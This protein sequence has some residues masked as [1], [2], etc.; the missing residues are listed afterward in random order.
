MIQAP[1]GGYYSIYTL[2]GMLLASGSI[3]SLTGTIPCPTSGIVIVKI[4]TAE[5]VYSYKQMIVK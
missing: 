5:T 3:N 2:D 1:E 4:Y